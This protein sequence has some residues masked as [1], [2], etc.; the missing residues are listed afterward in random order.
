MVS[1][2]DIPLDQAILFSTHLKRK[3]DECGKVRSKASIL[4]NKSTSRDPALCSLVSEEATEVQLP[5]TLLRSESMRAVGY[6][7]V[8]LQY[9][10]SK[11]ICNI[12]SCV[13]VYIQSLNLS[14]QLEDLPT[15]NI[16]IIT[17][18]GLKNL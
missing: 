7:S 18:K 12:M 14:R 13:C 10:A 15:C 11:A 1:Y 9:G 3:G 2:S 6:S 5:I 17:F 16:Q 8:M 4:G